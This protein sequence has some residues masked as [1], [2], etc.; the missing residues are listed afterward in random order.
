MV[1]WVTLTCSPVEGPEEDG[2][3][4]LLAIGRKVGVDNTGEGLQR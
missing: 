4:R 1:I 2:I 3:I